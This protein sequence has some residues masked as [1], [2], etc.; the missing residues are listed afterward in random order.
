ME[1]VRLL[2]VVLSFLYAWS[3]GPRILLLCQSSCWTIK[4]I[5][6]SGNWQSDLKSPVLAMM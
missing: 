2:G 5:R 1:P 6:S 3:L 4:E